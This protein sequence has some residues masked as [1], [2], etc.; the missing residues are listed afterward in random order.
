[1][2][3]ADEAQLRVLK[4]VLSAHP[5]HAAVIGAFTP[6]L[7]ARTRLVR[8]AEGVASA[9]MPFASGP[10]GRTVCAE[11]A[12][13]AAL[14]VLD[15]VGEGFPGQGD[16]CRSL[17]ELFTPDSVRRLCEAWFAGNA[18]F[19]SQWAEERGVSPEIPGF[20]TGQVCR[21]LAARAAARLPEHSG[22]GTARACPYC[23]SMPEL[24]VIHG[25]DG[26]RELVCGLCGRFWRYRRT[27]CPACGLDA[28]ENLQSL[29]VEGRPQERGVA[30]EAC[31]RYVLEVDIRHLDLAPDQCQ[32]LM[33]GLGHLD[34]LMQEEGKLPLSQ[35][36]GEC[37]CE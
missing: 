35:A 16:I 6:L 4:G 11:A 33:L 3:L 37:I 31:G 19:C 23:G 13:A 27:A 7:L 25:P 29:Y 8:E 26:R 20:V 21:V 30:C 32:A 36:S 15:A 18:S 10:D 22:D 34:M 28:P 14:A 9:S 1:M 12:H 5:E 24:S 17:R 2:P